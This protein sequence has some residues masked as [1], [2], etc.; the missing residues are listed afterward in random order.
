M[1]RV[2]KESAFSHIHLGSFEK[3]PK[4]SGVLHIQS[5][6]STPGANSKSEIP[7]VTFVSKIS[8][9][10][11]SNFNANGFKR[12]SISA[13]FIQA[14]FAKIPKNLGVLQI[15]SC[16]STP[17]ANCKSEVDMLNLRVAECYIVFVK[18]PH[19]IAKYLAFLFLGCGRRRKLTI[20]YKKTHKK[21]G[22]FR[23]R[24]AQVPLGY[25][26]FRVAQVPQVLQI[27]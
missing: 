21:T 27:I 15:Q 6:S 17:W 2:P 1:P 19:C 12:I 10:S 13:T 11:N 16:S 24:V 25:F 7:L 20:F 5:C 26:K 14:H 9:Q 23:F 3:N 4:K 22:Y 18:M 8:Y